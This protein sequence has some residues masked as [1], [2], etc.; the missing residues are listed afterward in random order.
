MNM[1]NDVNYVTLS[2]KLME[3][4]TKSATI[5]GTPTGHFYI[6]VHRT[7]IGQAGQ[8]CED[9]IDVQVACCGHP[10]N[11]IVKYGRPGVPVVVV[12]RLAVLPADGQHPLLTYVF[13]ETIAFPSVSACIAVPK[14]P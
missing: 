4:P 7:W 12:G 11:S 8:V 13:A 3:L 9:T 6:R 14:C 10:A 2:G 1:T 5:S